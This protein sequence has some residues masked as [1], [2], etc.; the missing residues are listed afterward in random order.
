MFVVCLLFIV[1]LY[2]AWDV[3]RQ[4]RKSVI[5]DS[6]DEE[7]SKKNCEICLYCQWL[8]SVSSLACGEG[9]IGV[10]FMLYNPQSDS[11]G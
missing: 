11:G 3:V 6:F 8:Y 2:K 9:E 4:K 10:N 5:A 7:Q 1:P